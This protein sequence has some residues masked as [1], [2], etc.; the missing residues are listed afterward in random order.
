MTDME[1]A[2]RDVWAAKRF[3][4]RAAIATLR[5]WP[6][7]TVMARQ[8]LQDLAA[9]RTALEAAWEGR[10]NSFACSSEIPRG[11]G[12]FYFRTTNATSRIETND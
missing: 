3:M 8:A 7:A 6:L 9:A 5:G 12:N 4:T 10:V 1:R 2:Y 11:Q